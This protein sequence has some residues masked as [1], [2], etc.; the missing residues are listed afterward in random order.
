MSKPVLDPGEKIR[1]K[2]RAKL[3]SLG[4]DPQTEYYLW[5]SDGNDYE[6]TAYILDHLP[7][8]VS[9]QI[10]NILD[11]AGYGETYEFGRTMS[12]ENKKDVAELKSFLKKLERLCQVHDVLHT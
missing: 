2:F 12:L 11:H 7:E 1:K 10:H 6:F 5:L 3:K 9:N 4:I 8:E